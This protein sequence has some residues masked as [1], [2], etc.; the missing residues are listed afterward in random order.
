LTPYPKTL[1]QRADYRFKFEDKV[2]D[3]ELKTLIRD[4][5]FEGIDHGLRAHC[6][7][8]LED[9]EVQQLRFLFD[10]ISQLGDGKIHKGIDLIIE[11]HKRMKKAR[12]RVDQWS[13][14]VGRVIITALVTGFFALC[15]WVF[16]IFSGLKH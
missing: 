7:I 12:S 15:V 11:D 6:R 5:I 3:P 1:E 14:H 8:P 16:N 9:F 13:V 10:G 2:T 4:A